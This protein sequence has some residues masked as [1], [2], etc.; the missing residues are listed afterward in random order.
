MNPPGFGLDN[1][2]SAMRKIAQAS[3]KY[4]ELSPWIGQATSNIVYKDSE[5]WFKRELTRLGYL[6]LT[7]WIASDATY[8]LDVQTTTGAFGESFDMHS[9]QFERVS[10]CMGP[11]NFWFRLLR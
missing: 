6:S 3:Q 9:A 10:F 4:R 7:D 2:T 1:W 5:G 8:Y 11:R